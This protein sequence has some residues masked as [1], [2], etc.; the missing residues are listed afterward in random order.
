MFIAG[1][2]STFKTAKLIAAMIILNEAIPNPAINGGLPAGDDKRLRQPGDLPG[3]RLPRDRPD[4]NIRGFL[5]ADL[6]EGPLGHGAAEL[7]HSDR[8]RRFGGQELHRAPGEPAHPGGDGSD[9][10]ALPE[11][12]PAEAADLQQGQVNT[13]LP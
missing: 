12:E 7:H 4:Q 8:R 11:H 1:L 6:P 3:L 5:A 9:H 2:G 10:Q 13:L